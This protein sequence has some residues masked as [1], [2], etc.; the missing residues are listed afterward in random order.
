MHLKIAVR[1]I[2]ELPI[3]AI[4]TLA[5]QIIKCVLPLRSQ[6]PIAHVIAASHGRGVAQPRRPLN[7]KRRTERLACAA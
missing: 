5:S 7:V 3:R 1:E 6:W 4:M 2:P